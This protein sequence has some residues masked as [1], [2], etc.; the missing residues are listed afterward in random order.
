MT[1]S[2]HV[3]LDFKRKYQEN[4]N[5]VLVEIANSPKK[6]VRV[7]KIT[8]ELL[9]WDMQDSKEVFGDRISKEDLP[10]EEAVEIYSA[11]LDK[12]PWENTL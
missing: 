7:E 1:R 8:E 3:L 5:E 6:R 11:W 10:K 2:E 4:M 9:G 12:Q